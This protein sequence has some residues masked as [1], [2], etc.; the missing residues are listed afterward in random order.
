MSNDCCHVWDE[1]VYQ[2]S[3]SSI[4][5]RLLPLNGKEELYLSYLWLWRKNASG[6]RV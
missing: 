4:S 6:G 1:S 3:L 5:S 2:P